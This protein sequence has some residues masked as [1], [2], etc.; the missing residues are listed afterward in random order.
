M[1]RAVYQSPTHT[2]AMHLILSPSTHL[3]LLRGV[4]DG[5]TP[6]HIHFGGNDGGV[7]CLRA[8]AF[9]SGL[10]FF[11]MEGRM[12]AFFRWT[13][14]WAC[15]CRCKC[16]CNVTWGNI[17]QFQRTTWGGFRMTFRKIIREVGLLFHWAC[18]KVDSSA[19]LLPRR[20]FSMKGQHRLCPPDAESE[21]VG[22]HG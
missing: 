13:W 7:C 2:P 5:T 12:G 8:K 15:C 20:P 19:W 21:F 1:Y 6:A 10:S 3:M 9:K 17:A 14:V 22:T 11:L 16:P 4:A 18:S